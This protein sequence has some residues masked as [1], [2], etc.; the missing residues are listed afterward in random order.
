MGYYVSTSA[1]HFHLDKEHF[2][3]A[4]QALCAINDPKYNHLK[5]GGSS[6]PNGQTAWWY[7]WMTEDYPATT[8]TVTDILDLLGFEISYDDGNIVGLDYDNKT[9]NEDIFFMALAPYVKDGSYIIWKGEDGRMWGWEFT[10]GHM[11]IR[12]V[13]LSLTG[14]RTAPT[15]L[16]VNRDTELG[17]D[18]HYEYRKVE[19]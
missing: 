16:H 8:E 14:D 6:G 15:Y 10:D 7:S 19:L 4:Y 18:G 12:D 13:E 1:T 9:G 17:A 2:P 11:W 3:A 5:S